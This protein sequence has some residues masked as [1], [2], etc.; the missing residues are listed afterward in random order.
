METG[1]VPNIIKLMDHTDVQI[2]IPAVRAMGNILSVNEAPHITGLLI[3]DSL[4]EVYKSL[5][6]HPKQILRKEIC[7]SLSNILAESATQ[8]A[9]C[10]QNG[11]IHSL[12]MHMQH[13]VNMVRKECC[14]SLTNALCKATPELA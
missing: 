5:I 7:W 11:V 13:D 3:D 10:L 4:L 12:I 8:I 9:K 2:A 1:G 6:D 14:W